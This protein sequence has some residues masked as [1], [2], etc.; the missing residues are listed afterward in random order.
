M[1]PSHSLLNLLSNRTYPDP[2]QLLINTTIFPLLLISVLSDTFL[3]GVSVSSPIPTLSLSLSL[4]LPAVAGR[5]RTH[6][7]YK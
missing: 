4:S 7:H 3:L 2:T 6:A 1:K 5:T